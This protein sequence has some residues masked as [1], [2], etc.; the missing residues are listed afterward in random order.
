MLIDVS[1]MRRNNIG[2]FKYPFS[3]VIITTGTNTESLPEKAGPD[4]G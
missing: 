1:S 4:Q 2:T 3:D